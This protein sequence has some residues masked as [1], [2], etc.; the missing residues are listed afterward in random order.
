VPRS[1]GLTAHALC[2]T[3]PGGVRRVV[4]RTAFSDYRGVILGEDRPADVRV[5]PVGVALDT[6]QD[7]D[8]DLYRD[9]LAQYKIVDADVHVDDTLPNMVRTWPGTTVDD[10]RRA[11]RSDM[12][13]SCAPSESRWRAVPSIS[14]SEP[15]PKQ[16]VRR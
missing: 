8:P 6:I 13:S 2:S 7:E 14:C 11:T 10:S 5:T 1:L 4:L 12:A 16:P 15:P 3:L 9:E